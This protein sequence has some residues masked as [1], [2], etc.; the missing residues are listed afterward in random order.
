MAFIP[1]PGFAEVTL[2]F[3]Q[4][5]GEQA[6]NVF[7]VDS[8]QTDAL[9]FDDLAALC[10]T[11]V[12]WFGTGDGTHSYKAL[13]QSSSSLVDV[14]ARDLTTDSG[15]IAIETA[16]VSGTDGG[17]KLAN[18]LT[19]TVT[20]RTALSGRSYRG[21]TF[22]VGLTDNFLVAGQQNVADSGH[23][24]DAINAFFPLIA[25]IAGTTLPDAA[26][27]PAL[28]VLSRRTAGAPRAAIVATPVT[29]FGYHDLFMDY[30]RRR[31]PG[32]NRH[33]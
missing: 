1:G 19:F 20:S 27:T 11:V 3:A 33:H 15:P 31:A 25:A 29:N 8:G 21:R 2:N 18:G 26:S 16:N 7:G 13:M 22:L 30:Q 17:G 6:V 12:D 9:T 4:G 10:V 14:R 23:A 28:A 5:D 24:D 32:H